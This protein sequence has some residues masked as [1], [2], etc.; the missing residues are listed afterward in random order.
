[1]FG[2]QVQSYSV[3][4]D[5]DPAADDDIPVFRAPHR[6]TIKN[7]YFTITNT[8]AASTANYFTLQL[9]NGGTAGTATDAVSSVT[10]GTPASGTAPGWT[11][12]TPTALT[13]TDGTVEAGE[14][15]VLRYDETGTGTFT[16][17][18]LQLDYVNGVG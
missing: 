6:L 16:S 15:L 9:L 17:G 12:L 8:L 3:F 13:V 2:D 1:M 18:F 4:L 7:S 5:Y 14:L 10:G 11:A